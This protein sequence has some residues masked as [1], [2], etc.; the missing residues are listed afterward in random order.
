MASTNKEKS[1][2]KDDKNGALMIRDVPAE[3]LAELDAWIKELES[4][5]KHGATYSRS[6]LALRLIMDGL[7][8]RKTK[9]NP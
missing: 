7:A 3:T 2:K 1:S 4:Q 8:N 6:G 5:D 9:G